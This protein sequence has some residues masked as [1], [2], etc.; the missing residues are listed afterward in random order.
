MSKIFHRDLAVLA[1][2]SSLING[3]KA[4]EDVMFKIENGQSYIKMIEASFLYY[5]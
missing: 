5:L 3:I 2:K 1:A 4:I